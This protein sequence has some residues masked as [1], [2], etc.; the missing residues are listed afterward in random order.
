MQFS[1]LSLLSRQEKFAEKYRL[2]FQEIFCS[3]GGKMAVKT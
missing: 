1:L 2:Y 3:I